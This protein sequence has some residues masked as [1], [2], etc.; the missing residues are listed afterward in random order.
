MASVPPPAAYGTTILTCVRDQLSAEA[1]VVARVAARM[2]PAAISSLCAR[3]MISSHCSDY[4]CVMQGSPG[5]HPSRCGRPV[6]NQH[7]A[8][9]AGLD[10]G[11]GQSEIPKHE[12]VVLTLEGGWRRL[13]QHIFRKVPGMAG[14]AVRPPE[15]VRHF[16]NSA[17]V[18]RPF[19]VGEFLQRPHDPDRDL[20]F[21]ELRIKGLKVRKGQ[22]PGLDDGVQGVVVAKTRRGRREAQVAGE[23]GTAHGA[24]VAVEC[25]AADDAL[26]GDETFASGAQELWAIRSSQHRR[27]GT[28]VHAF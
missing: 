9:D 16:A 27:L 1:T 20:R 10:L 13:I 19:R 15:S 23:T 12:I 11:F 24:K 3:M 21:V 28:R 18:T 5:G 8:P 7:L 22:D 25:K 6:M 2:P 26:G 4:L 17:P 14:Q